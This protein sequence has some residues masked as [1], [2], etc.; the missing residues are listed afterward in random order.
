MQA[1]TYVESFATRGVLLWREGDA[2]RYKAP[3]GVL[4]PAVLEKLREA[5]EKILP[6]LPSAAPGVS[7]GASHGDL[8]GLAGTPESE[9]RSSSRLAIS[10]RSD[11]PGPLTEPPD[12]GRH[13]TVSGFAWF[14]AWAEGEASALAAAGIVPELEPAFFAE[15]EALTL[16]DGEKSH[17]A[18]SAMVRRQ[19][20]GERFPAGEPV[21]DQSPI[22][23]LSP[24]SAFLRSRV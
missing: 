5:K 23:M 4:T 15:L 21:E 6:I 11:H 24:A 12:V 16:S 10:E 8:Q 20:P 19:R 14:R 7:I 17:Q 13:H 1:Q 2:L 3:P 9:L 22:A 18:V